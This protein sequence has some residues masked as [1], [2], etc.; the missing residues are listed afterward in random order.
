MHPSTPSRQTKREWD[1]SPSLHYFWLSIKRRCGWVLYYADFISL[2]GPTGPCGSG[3]D[4]IEFQRIYRFRPTLLFRPHWSNGNLDHLLLAPVFHD[5]RSLFDPIA[6]S[7]IPAYA[8]IDWPW[9][10]TS[11]S[12]SPSSICTVNAPFD[13]SNLRIVFSSSCPY[14]HL[15]H[16][17]A[18]DSSLM[19][20]LSQMN[21][22]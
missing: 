9:T 18:P 2:Y 10:T 11:V 14:F 22:S 13:P 3:D 19:K 21:V 6:I 20:P 5:N 15:W 12:S 4:E 8:W 17:P 7:V 16:P 1:R